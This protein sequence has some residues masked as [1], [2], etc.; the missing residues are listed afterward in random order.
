MS[1]CMRALC[2]MH[3]QK[4]ESAPSSHRR[5]RKCPL[6]AIHGPHY[7]ILSHFPFINWLILLLF[8]ALVTYTFLCQPANIKSISNTQPVYIHSSHL[9]IATRLR[10]FFTTLLKK[11]YK[12]Y[13][14]GYLTLPCSF[15]SSNFIGQPTL[16]T[17]CTFSP[18][19]RPFR[20]IF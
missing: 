16:A 5:T 1:I 3:R 9:A 18:L 4:R 10:L 17:Y 7:M 19:L 12:H 11:Q 13:T 20:P 2:H 8:D 15:I 6:Y 14:N